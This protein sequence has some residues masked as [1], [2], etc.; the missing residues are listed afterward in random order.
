MF[1]N[2]RCNRH[3]D[4]VFAGSQLCSGITSSSSVD[5]CSTHNNAVEGYNLRNF[6][7]SA[8]V[9]WK[10][11]DNWIPVPVCLRTSQSLGE[12]GQSVVSCTIVRH[13]KGIQINDQQHL[14]AN[15]LCCNVYWKVFIS[16]GLTIEDDYILSRKTIWRWSQSGTLLNLVDFQL[17]LNTPQNSLKSR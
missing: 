16:F 5:I 8:R 4:C 17:T 1:F 11:G 9:R 3:K 14:L 2:C 6:M 13:Q 10:L 12:P 7:S 15:V